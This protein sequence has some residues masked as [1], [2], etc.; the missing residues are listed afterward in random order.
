M[1]AL[2]RQ[3]HQQREGARGEIATVEDRLSVIVGL[4]SRRQR[5]LPWKSVLWHIEQLRRQIT[6]LEGR[7]PTDA[8]RAM[9]ET[10]EGLDRLF[11]D[12]DTV[13]AELR[14]EATGAQEHLSDAMAALR[15]DLH[16]ADQFRLQ[17]AGLEE[18]HLNA[19]E[20]A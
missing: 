12:L 20:V 1:S 7:R 9:R 15:I 13:L 14:A 2:T 11:G 16:L 17:A 5:V 3:S 10:V 18:S 6:R 19:T 4:V 8:T